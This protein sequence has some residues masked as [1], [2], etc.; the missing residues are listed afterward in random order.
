METGPEVV[1][2]AAPGGSM[3]GVLYAPEGAGPLPAVLVIMEA[4]GLNEHIRSVAARLASEGYIALAP[5]LYYRESERVIP[6][7]DRDRAVDRVMR[8]IALSRTPEERVKDD[9]VAA[10]LSAARAALAA[11]PRVDGDRIGVVGFS[12]G[13]RLAFLLAC[14]EGDRISAAVSFYGGHVVPIVE[15]AAELRAPVLLLFGGRDED[16]PA[17]HVDRIQAEFAYREKTHEV[18]VYPE[19]GHGFFCDDRASYRV[20]A[21]A[22]SWQRTL[23]WLKDY[24]S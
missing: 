22:D 16:I 18:L 17:S 23:E 20:E 7:G 12:M 13:G 6:Y 11:D 14:R 24:L 9:R 19:A 8:T 10:D 15:E 1:H 4:F 3:P 2:I 5:D 21:A